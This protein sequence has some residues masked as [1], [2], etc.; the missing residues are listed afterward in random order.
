ML[1]EVAKDLLFV[2]AMVSGLACT[3]NGGA[4]E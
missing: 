3:I 4:P 2:S 1:V